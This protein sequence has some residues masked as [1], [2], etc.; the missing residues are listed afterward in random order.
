MFYCACQVIQCRSIQKTG[1]NGR[2]KLNT[3]SFNATRHY[4]RVTLVVGALLF[5]RMGGEK[6][7]KI[8]ES[9]KVNLKVI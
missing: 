6:K 7:I 3:L 1:I 9:L 5:R 4:G 2:L 8:K